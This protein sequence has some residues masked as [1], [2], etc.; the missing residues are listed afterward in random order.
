MMMK[1][2]I[3]MSNGNTFITKGR[4]KTCRNKS[5]TLKPGQQKAFDKLIEQYK[6]IFAE[7]INELG[8]TNITKHKIEVEKDAKPVKQQY[9]RT[10]PIAKEFFQGEVKRLLRRNH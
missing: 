1:I 4:T 7:E 9:Y 6:D 2:V 10:N 5:R 8:R 3:G